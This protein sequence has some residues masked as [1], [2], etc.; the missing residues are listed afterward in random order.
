MGRGDRCGSADEDSFKSE[1]AMDEAAT[2]RHAEGGTESIK[3]QRAPHARNI[4]RDSLAECGPQRSATRHSTV[5]SR[6][7]WSGE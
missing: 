5:Q 2:P 7:E 4:Q 1:W 3:A 6:V